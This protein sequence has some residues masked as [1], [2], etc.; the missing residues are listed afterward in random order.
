MFVNGTNVCEFEQF[1]KNMHH[2]VVSLII[3]N[4]VILLNVT[5]YSA[6]NLNV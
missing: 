2:T 5:Q 6:V 3:F 1:S 4:W